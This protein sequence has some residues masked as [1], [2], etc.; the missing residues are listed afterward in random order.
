LFH[1]FGASLWELTWNFQA[2]PGRQGV[3]LAS[4]CIMLKSRGEAAY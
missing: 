2:L 1:A 3:A 4:N